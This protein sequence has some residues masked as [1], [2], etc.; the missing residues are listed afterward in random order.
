[1]TPNSS[2]AALD[3]TERIRLLDSLN[4]DLEEQ[5]KDLK[6]LKRLSEISGRSLNLSE[7]EKGG[8]KM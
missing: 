5:L 4:K 8:K 3:E 1:M 6:R 2:D 7:E